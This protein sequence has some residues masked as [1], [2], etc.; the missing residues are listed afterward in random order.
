MGSLC[1]RPR[2]HRYD[3]DSGTRFICYFNKVKYY[4][5][6]HKYYIKDI[7]NDDSI[8]VI[9][10]NN[11]RCHGMNFT[12]KAYKNGICLSYKDDVDGMKN[13]N[14][15][16]RNGKPV[17]D[18][19]LTSDL[20]FEPYDKD[21]LIKVIDSNSYLCVDLSN[22]RDDNEYGISY[23]VGLTK[24]RNKATRFQRIDK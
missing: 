21:I 11:W 10:H 22:K 8:F 3:E 13:W 20:V 6:C 24:D 9:V 18:R 7:L 2:P 5:A 16:I 12:I 15:Y 1:E 23:Y 19:Y 4:L 17:F 14:L